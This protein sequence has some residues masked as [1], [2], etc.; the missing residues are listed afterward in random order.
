M[1]ESSERWLRVLSHHCLYA[2]QPDLSP[3]RHVRR[4]KATIRIPTGGGVEALNI[5]RVAAAVYGKGEEGVVAN[6][7][8]MEV[9]APARLLADVIDTGTSADRFSYL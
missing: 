8:I 7:E 5:A 4:A 6:S 3:G 2:W 1:S 9:T